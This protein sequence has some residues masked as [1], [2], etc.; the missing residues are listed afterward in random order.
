M[1]MSQLMVL[2]EDTRCLCVF[3]MGKHSK[4]KKLHKTLSGEGTKLSGENSE[5]KTNSAENLLQPSGQE[6]SACR[7][8]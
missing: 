8:L 3:S 7:F 1:W 2:G 4:N 5:K 6:K